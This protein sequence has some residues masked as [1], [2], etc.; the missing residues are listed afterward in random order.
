[1]AGMFPTFDYE[2]EMAD[3][4][5]R[6]KLADAM[7]MTALSPMEMPQ[8]AGPVASKASWLAPIA[9]LAQAYFASK[10]AETLKGDRQAATDR[11]NTEGQQGV[12]K[13]M[14]AM[15]QQPGDYQKPGDGVG[16]A[17]YRS[18]E[19]VA[20][21]KKTALYQ[22]MAANHP[23]LREL[24]MAEFKRQGAQKDI[25][26]KDLLP[27][28]DPATIPTLLA[29]G[30]QSFKPK[31]ELGEVG[32]VV[33]D[34]HTKQIVQLKQGYTPGAVLRI[35]GADGQIDLYQPNPSTGKLEKMDNAPKIT[36]K[37]GVNVTNAGENAF[38]KKVGELNAN[39]LGDIRKA[40]D[41]ARKM[42]PILQK[43]EGL[44]NATHSG[45][46]APVGV[47]L[48]EL[49]SSMGVPVDKAK[50]ANSEEYAGVL[51][52]QISNYLTAGA[53]VGRSLTDADRQALEA[54]FPGLIRT[55]EGRV[56]IIRTLREANMRDIQQADTAEQE[57]A[58]RFP[59]LK[60]LVP[61]GF[62]GSPAPQTPNTVQPSGGPVI[63]NW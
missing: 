6:Q 21:M 8:N 45:P 57:I 11:Y 37:V 32:G 28:A 44:S 54:Q 7:Q 47:W 4:A 19:E 33:Y 43:L 18:P 52:K 10:Q 5:R 2:T 48:G 53:G 30:V 38:A 40:G 26:V 31:E 23:I 50:L 25:T 35:P 22:A 55:P 17:N 46:G 56:K 49:A 24:A 39:E 13:L 9:K 27:Y 14:N 1:M 51:A 41:S 15:T 63:R 42:Q 34:K 20:T 58:K 16:P 61:G 36:N 60:R 29:N 3:I 62:Q 59:D 12:E